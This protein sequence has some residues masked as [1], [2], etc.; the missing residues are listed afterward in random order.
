MSDFIDTPLSRRLRDYAFRSPREALIEAAD[1]IDTL[2]KRAEEAE[3][4][5]DELREIVGK[6]QTNISLTPELNMSNY[7][8]EQVETLNYSM[9]TLSGLVDEYLAAESARGDG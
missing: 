5:R 3:A 2:T 7:D 8:E 9:I 4:E 1:T 6:I